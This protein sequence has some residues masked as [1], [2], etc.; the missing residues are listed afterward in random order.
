MTRPALRNIDQRHIDAAMK[1]LSNEKYWRGEVFKNKPDK[2]ARKIKEIE[3]V[4]KLIIAM[5]EDIETLK[6]QPKIV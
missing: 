1:V 3:Y 5:F 4:E 2:M 6:K